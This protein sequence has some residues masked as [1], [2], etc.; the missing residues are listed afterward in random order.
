MQAYLTHLIPQLSQF[1]K[2]LDDFALFA[3][4]P[5]VQVGGEGRTVF[6]FRKGGELLVSR[7]GDV[8]TARWEHLPA[9]R[10]IVVE[11][12]GQKTLYNQGFLDDAILALKKDGVDEYL[13]L[14]NENEV[15][16]VT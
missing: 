5:W 16:P 1:S 2:G 3:D 13:L 12:D 9:L 4:H 7:N 6:V 14:G 15:G 11:K 8:G 10:S